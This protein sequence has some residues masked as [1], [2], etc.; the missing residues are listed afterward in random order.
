MTKTLIIVKITGVYKMKQYDKNYIRLIDL[1]N[2]V[3]FRR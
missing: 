3:W 2:F 1:I